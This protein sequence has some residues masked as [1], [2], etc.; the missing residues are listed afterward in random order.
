MEPSIKTGSVILVQKS[1]DYSQNDVITY[2]N[3]NKTYVTH[4]IA[5]K[6]NGEYL[7]SG[8]A[9][10]TFD[11]ERVKNEQIVGKVLFSVPYLGYIGNF[12]KNP[13]G[14]ILLVIVPTTIIIYEELK[15]LKNQFTKIKISKPISRASI[16]IPLIF[17]LFILGGISI[18]YFSDTEKSVQNI[19]GASD[20][21]P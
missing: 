3:V 4:R 14:F 5:F 16:L 18:A 12:A 20:T 10:K 2:K 11:T 8:D 17:S 15:Y 13:K 19:F 21:F 9:N 1:S 6:E 7:L